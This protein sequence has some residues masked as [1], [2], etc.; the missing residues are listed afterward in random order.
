MFKITKIIIILFIIHYSFTLYGSS[1]NFNFTMELNLNRTFGYTQYQIG[2]FLTMEDDQ[3]GVTQD[4]LSELVFP[5][6][7]FVAQ[8]NLNLELSS[9]Y[10]FKLNLGTN[11]DKGI[12]KMKDSDFGI[13]WMQRRCNKRI[14]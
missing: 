1:D 9:Y 3:S 13:W 2:G 10:I 12:G 4:P 5:A 11:I 14:C 6:E 7:F 8:L